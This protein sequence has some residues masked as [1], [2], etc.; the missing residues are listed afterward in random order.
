MSQKKNSLTF[1]R[2]LLLYFFFQKT[3]EICKM[4]QLAEF[5]EIE[6]NIIDEKMTVTVSLID[7]KQ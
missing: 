4:M 7:M 5:E 3:K 6:N 1:K 2:F